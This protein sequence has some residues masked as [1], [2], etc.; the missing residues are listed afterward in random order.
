MERQ[1]T[2]LGQQ[3]VQDGEKATLPEGITAVHQLIGPPLE[4]PFK[5]HLTVNCPPLFREELILYKNYQYIVAF[6]KL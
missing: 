6:K 4:A 2:F 5:S 3:G 1:L